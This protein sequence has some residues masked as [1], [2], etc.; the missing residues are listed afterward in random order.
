MLTAF[1]HITGSLPKK[2]EN[3][4]DHN[5]HENASGTIMKIVKVPNNIY[6]VYLEYVFWK[7]G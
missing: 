7:K 1:Q 5:Y 6:T 3:C 2:E 4:G